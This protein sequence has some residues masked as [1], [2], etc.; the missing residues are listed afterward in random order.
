MIND[1]CS[2]IREATDHYIPH[3]WAQGVFQWDSGAVNV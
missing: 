1:P 2:N 3:T